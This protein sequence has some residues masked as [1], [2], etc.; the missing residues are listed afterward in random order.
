MTERRGGGEARLAGMD[1]PA[2]LRSKPTEVEY[3]DIGFREGMEDL[4]SQLDQPIRL[5][6]LSGAGMLAPR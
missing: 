5:R 3:V 6:D 4:E 1:M 2:V